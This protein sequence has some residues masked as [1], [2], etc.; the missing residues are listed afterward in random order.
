MWYIGAMK[1]FNVYCS[2]TDPKCARTALAHGADGIGLVRTE[3]MIQ[4]DNLFAPY[5]ASYVGGTFGRDTESAARNI[6][7]EVDKF[8]KHKRIIFRML[9]AKHRGIRGARLLAD[10]PK[11]LEQQA[12]GLHAGHAESGREPE[13]LVPFITNLQDFETV[14]GAAR[15]VGKCRVGAMIENAWSM[16]NIGELAG[17][18]DFIS[19]GLNDLTEDMTGHSEA[20]EPSFYRT[21]SPAI[22]NAIE[23]ATE[24]ARGARPDVE[25]GFCGEHTNFAENY[26]LFK[27]VGASS[28][29]VRP[30]YVHV[31][32]SN[33][34]I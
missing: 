22:G 21:L 5:Y 30:A 34:G 12:I 20:T 29:T 15:K 7:R 27:Q 25:I 18:A 2:L 19:V 6:V 17:M 14:A 31:A 3:K 24:R 8:G 33:G 13:L 28:V 4:P 10:N 26:K 23:T 1:I 9:D 32:R 16:E 11:I